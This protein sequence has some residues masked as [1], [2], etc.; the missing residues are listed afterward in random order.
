MSVTVVVG[1]LARALL[2][3]EDVVFFQESR[4]K[5]S[6]EHMT[7]MGQ[8][9]YGMVWYGTLVV[10]GLGWLGLGRQLRSYIITST[11]TRVPCLSP[12]CI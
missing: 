6:R 9:W 5:Q 12:A 10:L 3:W 4:C 8:V 1:R 11:N 7:A 2:L